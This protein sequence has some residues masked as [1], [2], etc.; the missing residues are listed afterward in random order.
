MRN[1]GLNGNKEKQGNRLVSFVEI[2]RGNQ[3]D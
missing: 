3:S 1:L 2:P